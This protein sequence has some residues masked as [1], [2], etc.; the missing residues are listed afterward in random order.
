V[1]VF[2]FKIKSILFLSIVRL[3]QRKTI[4][5]FIAVAFLINISE[6]GEILE[7]IANFKDNLFGGEFLK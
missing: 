1:T 6:S 4:I 7:E 5:G 3:F 2:D